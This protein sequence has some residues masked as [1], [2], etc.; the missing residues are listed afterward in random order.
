MKIIISA[1]ALLTVLSVSILAQTSSAT[2]PV[3]TIKRFRWHENVP[4]V[5]CDGCN[6]LPV[7]QKYRRDQGPGAG[8]FVAYIKLKNVSSKRIKSV[9]VDFIFRDIVT[10]KEFLTYHLR[11]D[12]DLGRG[13]TKEIWHKIPK[14]KEPDNFR[15]AGP[16]LELVKSTIWCGNSPLLYDRK[17][18]QMVRIRDDAK[19]LKMQ[20]CYYTP[21]VTRIEYTDGSVWEPIAHG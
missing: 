20:P 19:L 7:A 5:P 9:N 21:I 4:S 14:G 3:L 13:Q 17:T 18:R 2:E 6:D 11:F 10:E 16:S 15:P 8:D 1:L 12:R